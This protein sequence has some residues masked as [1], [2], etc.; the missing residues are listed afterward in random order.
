VI[1]A[2]V[3]IGFPRCPGDVMAS[4]PAWCQPLSGWSRYFR[5]WMD[6]PN[7]APV[8]AAQIHFDLRPI[9]GDV[10]LGA[11]LRELI[12]R[13]APARRLFLGLLARDIVDR[14]V[15]LTVFGNVA[16]ERRGAH[17]G[18]VDVK[19]G[20]TIPLAGGARVTA[21]ELGLTETNTIDRIRVAGGRGVYTEAEARDLADAFQ[22][23]TR[24]RLV[25]QL[26]QLAHGKRPDNRVRVDRLSRADAL[27]FRDAL[28]TVQHLQAILRDRFKTDLLR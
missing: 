22:H 6:E 9:A 24:I 20:A 23:V 1:D 2:L 13:E 8:L 19:A 26:D 21:L 17:R 25:H 4:N 12:V 14:P 18:T 11:A 28:R 5:H 3:T 7:P 27:L 10:S 15:P 16:V